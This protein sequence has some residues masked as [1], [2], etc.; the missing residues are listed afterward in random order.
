VSGATGGTVA[1][2]SQAGSK[3]VVKLAFS[4]AYKQRP[5]ENIDTFNVTTTV[6]GAVLAGRFLAFAQKTGDEPLQSV[7][8][9]VTI[10][11]TV[12]VTIFTTIS[13]PISIKPPTD[14]LF[15]ST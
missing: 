1:A 10:F 2:T 5:G 4:K 14:L 3:A 6:G 7:T 8:I 15:E 13:V 12:S 9:S 11:V